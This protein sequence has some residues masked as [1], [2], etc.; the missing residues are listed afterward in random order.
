[1]H[2]KVKLLIS[3]AVC[4]MHRSNTVKRR[5][6]EDGTAVNWINC[7]INEEVTQ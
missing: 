6:Q 1:M 3:V 2:R 4:H 7:R 5:A